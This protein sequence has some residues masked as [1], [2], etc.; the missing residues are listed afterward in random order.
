MFSLS[1]ICVGSIKESYF[2]DAMMEYVKRCKP[3]AHI[4]IHEIPEEPFGPHTDAAKTKAKEAKKILSLIPERSYC[5]A[6]DEYGKEYTSVAFASLLEEHSMRGDT[7]VCIIGGPRGLDPEITKKAHL[8]LSFSRMTFPHQLMRVIFF[9]Q[10]YRA[11]T[12]SKGKQY[13]Y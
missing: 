2:K 11:I 12:I 8:V 5:I 3:Y 13:H 6:L 9:E 4:T 7:I 1:L 10:V